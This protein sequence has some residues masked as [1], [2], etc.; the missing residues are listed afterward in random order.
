MTLS[1]KQQ[2][3]T[4]LIGQLITWAGDHGYRLTF[5]EAYRT[6]EQAARNAKTGTGIANSLHTQRLAV[7]FNLFINGV[8]QT[9]TEAYTPLGEYW[10]S[11]GGAWG[12]RF[13]DRPDG[14]HFSLAH[15]GR[16]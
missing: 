10:E 14:N 2:L 12:G 15:D 1:E 9:Q 6:P 5:G 11:L 4:A 16:R 8:Y 7:D 3:F 13:K